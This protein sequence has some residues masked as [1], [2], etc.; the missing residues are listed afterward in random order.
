MRNLI[1]VFV[2][3]AVLAG[4][5]GVAVADPLD[6]TPDWI[7]AGWTATGTGTA[8][9][10]GTQVIIVDPSSAP[11]EFSSLLFVADD[12]LFASGFTLTPRVSL[13]HLNSVDPADGNT[14]VHLTFSDGIK[15]AR[16]VLLKAGTNQVRVAIVTT[17]GYAP[18]VPTRF[19]FPPGLVAE[20]TFGWDPARGGVSLSV[21]FL[22]GEPEEF[23]FFGELPPVA[24]RPGVKTIEFGSYGD[25]L[26]A[27]VSRWETL[28]LPKAGEPVP[29]PATLLL[30]GSGLAGIAGYGRKKLF[31]KG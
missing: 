9:G 19:V 18:S 26:A 29:E 17:A 3:L 23:A 14:G 15:Q 10:L 31:R 16:A 28:G 21:P 22:P 5:R 11:G 2:I 13:D 1:P 4:W 25:P 6:P 12:A 20:F 24:T 7:A 30:L 27:G 8:P